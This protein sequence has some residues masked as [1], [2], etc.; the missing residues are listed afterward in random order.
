MQASL[1]NTRAALDG[2]IQL[3]GA[4]TGG[5]LDVRLDSSN[6][7]ELGALL[8]QEALPAAPLNVQGKVS[9]QDRRLQF[10][11]LNVDLAGHKA[12]VDGQ[13]NTEKG[14][15]GSAL[16]V[17]LDSP[18][19]GGLA[20]LFGQEGIPNEPMDLSMQLRQEGKGLAFRA[21]NGN[22]GEIT[23]QVDGHVED[24]DEPFGLDANFDIRLPTLALLGF[25][26]ADIPLPD[27]PLSAR[28]SLQNMQTRTTL[29]DVR[30]TLGA[31]AADVSGDLY[32]NQRFAL[33]LEIR[34]SDASILDTLIG[35][36]LPSQPFSASA[37]LEG[38]PESFT[39]DNLDASLGE[40]KVGGALQIGL[41][42]PVSISGRV[43]SPYLDLRPFLTG[44][45]LE[46]PAPERPSEAELVFGEEPIPRVEDLGLNLNLE[47][48][49]DALELRTTVLRGVD[50]GIELAGNRLELNPLSGRGQGGGEVMGNLTLDSSGGDPEL[51][52]D[53]VATDLRLGLAAADDQA[54]DTFPTTN[55]EIKL[56]GRGATQRQMASSLNGG[57]RV[58]NGEGQVAASGVQFLLG[59]FLTEL[60]T[61]LNPFAKK[62]EYTTLECA[63]TAAT[64]VDGQVKI[65][66]A[67]YQTRELT[68]LSQGAIDLHTEK[69]DLS[70]NTKPRKG[71][72][73]SASVLINPAIKVGG[74]LGAPAIELDPVGAA[75]SGGLAIATVGISL[76]AKSAYDRFLSSKDP[77]GD[78]RAEIAKLDAGESP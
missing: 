30:F 20:A 25:L 50:L 73:I 1:G 44:E 71:I 64:I 7:A 43:D 32:A 9:R 61:A 38:S 23:L 56:V 63:V 4:D 12:R 31:I 16:D 17:R 14:Y 72:G 36:P 35:R 18:D 21:S 6:L 67:V 53:F 51:R 76:L 65:F 46:E 28:G 10:E 3:A 78:A 66:P 57:L 55:A 13:L 27:L 49:F 39:V 15:T 54:I 48:R 19:I 58:Y 45:E 77:C 29:E 5:T 11:G 26:A 60:F 33:E 37:A 52:L 68:I 47:L 69:L 42:K 59:D 74:R 62:S 40:S 34:G 8:G 2:E 24:L 22:V 75:A 41:G 70:F